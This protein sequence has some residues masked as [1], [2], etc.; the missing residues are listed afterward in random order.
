MMALCVQ[1]PRAVKS[2]FDCGFPRQS[3]QPPA[4]RSAALDR[5][6]GVVVGSPFAQAARIKR[7]AIR[8][9]YDKYG[10]WVTVG[11]E[12][13]KVWACSDMDYRLWSAYSK[14]LQQY[15]VEC[16]RV[17]PPRVRVGISEIQVG[18]RRLREATG[19]CFFFCGK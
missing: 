14:S 10:G 2:L 4:R 18:V 12:R 7:D 19:V 17:S 3:V 1:H 16:Q 11:G 15:L 9:L 13:S 6:S 5:C 8:E